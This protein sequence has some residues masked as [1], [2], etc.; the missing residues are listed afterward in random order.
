MYAIEFTE[1]AK[2]DVLLL[3][4]KAPNAVS[5][6]VKLLAELRQHPRTGTGQVERLKHYRNETWS[7]RITQEHRIVYEIHEDKIL[8]LVISAYGHY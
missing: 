7:R 3:Q 2:E 1:D 5:K 8:V 4:R 6:L